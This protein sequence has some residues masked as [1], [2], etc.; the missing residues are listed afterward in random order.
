VVGDKPQEP[1][2][3]MSRGM[4]VDGETVSMIP[5]WV[6]DSNS[7]RGVQDVIENLKKRDD[8]GFQTVKHH[9][10]QMPKLVGKGKNST[11]E[12]CAGSE[13]IK[14]FVFHVDNVISSCSEVGINDFLKS[15]RVDV[16]S[17]FK[18]KSWMPDKVKEQVN[19]F[20]VCVPNDCK[21][22]VMNAENWPH[23]VVLR[24]WKFKAGTKQTK[25]VG[26]VDNVS[27]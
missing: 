25:S 21:D 23:G 22:I 4:S 3:N 19:S 16:I 15:Q 14:K 26:S 9:K 1:I 5:R 11:S 7:A 10:M 18:V 12:V 6:I 27:N 24:E 20:R 17:V 8:D 2:Q 13:I